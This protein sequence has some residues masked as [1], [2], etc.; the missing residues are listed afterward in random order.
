MT[1]V[2]VIGSAGMLGQ[3]LVRV[4]EDLDVAGTDRASLDIRIRDDV[5]DAVKGFD[6]VI[7]AAAYTKV[8]QAEVD[9]DAAYA[10]NSTGARNI[11]LATHQAG[12]RLIQI[13]TDYVFDGESHEPYPELHP[14]NPLSVYGKSKRDGELAVV[15][16][17]PRSTIVR[18]S[19]LYG[20]QGPNFP[21]TISNL[22]RKE[23]DISI[24]D[25]QI[26]QPTYARD[27]A[28]M[29][30]SL[31]M[32][33][34]PSG[35]FHATNSGRA[36]WFQFARAIFERAGWDVDRVKATT[37]DQF[38]RPA[39]RP[40]WSVLGHENWESCGFDKPRTWQEALDDAWT[41]YLGQLFADT[42]L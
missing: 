27:V 24:V 8:D 35:I 10:V 33:G 41:N 11:G 6:V 2:M 20:S 22:G 17:N 42:R 36:S 40:Q 25:D 21:Q 12:S 3:E 14:T 29:V 9:K 28:T 13:S 34:P 37:S 1:R 39:P 16:E 18:T 23:G 31:V 7:N 5:V 30:R 19:W 38:V 4:L 32:D 15:E 26:G